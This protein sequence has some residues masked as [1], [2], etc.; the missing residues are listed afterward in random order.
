VNISPGIGSVDLSGSRMVSPTETTTYTITAQGATGTNPVTCTV[1]VR[2]STVP[3]PR[4]VNFTAAP[5]TINAG[6]SSN[7]IW[8]VEGATTVSISPNVGTVDAS[9]TRAVTPAQTTQ[10]TLTATNQTGTTTATTTITVIPATSGPLISACSATPS[11]SAGAGAP[12][13]LAYTS[14]NATS[15]SISGVSGT[16]PLQGPFTVNPQQTT[17]YT[18]T[19]TGAQGT[20]PA[21]CTVTVT[22]STPGPATL[23]FT[24]G[25]MAFTAV[26]TVAVRADIRGGTT[27]EL[28][29]LTYHW[30]PLDA[31]VVVSGQGTNNVV[32]QA[33]STPGDYRFLLTVTTATGTTID[34]I[35]T[36][37]Y[38]P[39]LGSTL[40]DLR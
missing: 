34:A 4:I 38:I 7:L 30:Q 39:P 31:G 2:V 27:A 19:A 40:S 23:F 24:P 5:M 11:T 29:S 17:T 35:E 26:R 20:T 10:Y 33:G 28:A 36:L 1:T 22:V 32:L 9:G 15:V 3:A 21:T 14:T 37:R 13:S 8:S 16:I 6:Q 25:P 18:I 12:V